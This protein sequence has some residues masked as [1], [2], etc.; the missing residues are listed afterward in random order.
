ML[1]GS[2]AGGLAHAL[3]G[4]T[5]VDVPPLVFRVGQGLVGVVIGAMVELST[6]RAIGA[7]WVSV[8]L[9]TL[10]GLS[11]GVGLFGDSPSR[12]SRMLR[13]ASHPLDFE[14]WTS[15]PDFLWSAWSEPV[16]WPG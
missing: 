15:A 14:V 11:G 4:R 8:T 9:V 10:S 12:P 13:G 2:L 6:L 5:V 16:S 7:D 1:F 3:T